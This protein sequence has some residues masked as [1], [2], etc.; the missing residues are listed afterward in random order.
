MT[1]TKVDGFPSVHDQIP[2]PLEP[3]I[4]V[5]SSVSQP[6]T[7][8]AESEGLH[9]DPVVQIPLFAI[10]NHEAFLTGASHVS[11][12]PP[13]GAEN[14]RFSLDPVILFLLITVHD[15]HLFL[16]NASN[17][18]QPPTVWLALPIIKAP[19]HLSGGNDGA[20]R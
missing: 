13:V 2:L 5:T 15:H 6:L 4:L 18:G 8:R 16:P 9:F 17:I 11:Q 19:R 20:I 12:S 3:S 7:I 1:A 14:Q 10:H